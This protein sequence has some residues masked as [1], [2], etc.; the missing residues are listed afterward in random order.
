MSGQSLGQ[1]AGIAI[2]AFFGPIGM[3]I[4]G[5]VGGAVGATFDPTQKFEGPRLSD[6]RLQT[7]SYGVD[8]PLVY[9][10]EN[11]LTGTVIWS[12]GLIE[13]RKKKKSGGKGGGGGSSVTT[14][15]YRTSV[16]VSLSE[17]TCKNIR[18]IWGNG[19][20]LFDI[21]NVANEVSRLETLAASLET[22]ALAAESMAA[23]DPENVELQASAHYWR[24]KANTAAATYAAAVAN[25]GAVGTGSAPWVLTRGTGLPNGPIGYLAFYPGDTTQNPDPKI[26]AA[27]GAG[28]VPAYRNTCYV[29]LGDLQLANFGN[30]LPNLE[31]E[32]DGLA[33]RSIGEILYD[34]S[35]RSGMLADEFKVAG[36]LYSRQVRGYAVSRA[37]NSMAA[38]TPLQSIYAFDTVEQNGEVRF[39][40]R[41]IG[42]VATIPLAD[43]GARDRDDASLAPVRL[44]T[45]RVPDFELVKEVAVTHRDPARDYQNN[46]QRATRLFG[47]AFS[48]ITE[49]VQVVLTASEARQ[50]AD[51]KLWETWSN[52]SLA[53]IEVSDKY[54]FLFAGDV[55][56]LEVFDTYLPF[57]IENRTKGV[58]GQIALELRMED[59][60][61]YQGSILGEAAAIPVNDAGDV[62]ETFV[63]AI[64]TPIINTA[65]TSTG[66][67]WVMDAALSGW[68]GGAI[69]RSVDSTAS[70]SEMASS[71]ERNTTGTVAIALPPGATEIW[72]RINTVTVTLLHP[73]HE[74]ES[75]PE[76]DVLNG[77]N[78]F[79]LG[80]ADGSHGEV[81]QFATATLV[82]SDPRVYVLSDLL[83]GRRATEHEVSLHGADELF[84]FFESDLLRTADYDVADWDR[85]RQYKGV[86]VYE[87]EDDVANYQTFI[88]T[89]ERARPRSPVH[90]A[91]TRDAG[92]DLTITWVPRIRGFQPGLGYGKVVLDEAVEAYEIDIIV[93]GNPV[94]TLTASTPTVAYSAA[95]Q[96]ADGIAPGNPVTLKIYQLSATRG[97]GHAGSFV[98]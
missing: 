79:W 4:G 66:F 41:G 48:V 51:R 27:L 68:A 39:V 46:T 75:L 30:S 91:G 67:L 18:R 36:S 95:Q 29:V 69:Y 50:V 96:T 31:F 62:G 58:N 25:Y 84:V 6:L 19:K 38:I 12:S 28:N 86:S 83:R 33:P 16:A 87:S 64:N 55:I 8:L 82:S 3:A 98:V 34:I 42:P 92:N 9:G 65:Q 32:L 78:A 26:E 89:G 20:L 35:K 1:L 60:F 57:R 40:P 88:N 47:N 61:V 43:I 17:G 81:I 70:F 85:E 76:I 53:H 52:R 56:A 74:L 14:Y 63:A 21:T 45:D 24:T 80:A 22:Q 10:P 5:A 37:G 13:T 94:R 44:L 2:G 7:S 90:G 71:G 11:R 49:E 59:P 72:D 77:K 23:T 73:D 93:A 97:R 54:R 15:S